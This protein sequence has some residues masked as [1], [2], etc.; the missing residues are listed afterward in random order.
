MI[1]HNS[2]GT[3]Q[4]VGS[5]FSRIDFSDIAEASFDRDH[6]SRKF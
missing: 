1:S 2:S 6:R 3:R 5:G 4:M